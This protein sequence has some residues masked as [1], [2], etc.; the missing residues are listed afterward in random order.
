MSSREYLRAETVGNDSYLAS[1][2]TTL[3]S[4]MARLQRRHESVP[5]VSRSAESY[6]TCGAPRDRNLPRAVPVVTTPHES[7]R[8]WLAPPRDVP[9]RPAP[10]STRTYRSQ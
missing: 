7:G 3:P 4:T 2:L 8:I 6:P 1:V 10:R 9:P 5:R